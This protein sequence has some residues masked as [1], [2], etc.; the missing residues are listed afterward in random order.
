MPGWQPFLREK[1]RS[2]RYMLQP[3]IGVKNPLTV[4]NECAKH[5][6]SLRSPAHQGSIWH[7]KCQLFWSSTLKV[8]PPKSQEKLGD[9]G[10]LICTNREIQPNRQLE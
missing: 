7:A 2:L 9:L 5:Y 3:Q 4:Q 1:L 8:R 10:I 6:L